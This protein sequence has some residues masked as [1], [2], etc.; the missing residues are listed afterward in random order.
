MADAQPTQMSCRAYAKSRGLS[1][2][3]VSVAI[4]AGRL[5]KC[6]TRNEFGQ[7][8]IADAALADQEW[9]A[10]TDQ[11][12]ARVASPEVKP[13]PVLTAVRSVTPLP[14][15]LPAREPSEDPDEPD[16]SM[17]DAAAREKHW[18]AK[19]AELKY[20]AAAGELVPASEVETSWANTL[21]QVRTKL[22]GIP[23]QFRQALPTL[24]P[25]DLVL[26]E[27]LIREALENLVAA[28]EGD[29]LDEEEIE[30]EEDDDDGDAE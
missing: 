23:T 10:N 1:A 13:I 12:R 19:L 21:S 5:V 7:P 15:P 6:I 14:D 24:T 8:K 28:D 11:T 25:P 29:D 4:A 16:G 30:E 20:K 2:N 22:L 17:A 9:N 18:R 3:A 26:L 27:N